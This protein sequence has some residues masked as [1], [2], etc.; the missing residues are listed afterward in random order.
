MY[1]NFIHSPLD[2]YLGCFYVLTIVNNASINVRIHVSFSVIAFSG[3]LP[4]SGIASCGILFLVFKEI[5]I[6]HSGCISLYPTSSTSPSIEYS[7]LISFRIDRFDLFTLQG[8][9]GSLFQQ[10]NSK[11]S[12][13]WQ[14]AFFM[15]QVLQI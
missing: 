4:S 1:H 9:L 15:I 7:G 14:L 3:Y 13:L 8:T 2:G 11:A 5:S 12:I 6:V 10:H